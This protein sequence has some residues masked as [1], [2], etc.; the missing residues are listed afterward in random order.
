MSHYSNST[1]PATSTDNYARPHTVRSLLQHQ[2]ADSDYGAAA[3]DMPVY[4][5]SPG[6]CIDEQI[7]LPLSDEQGHPVQNLGPIVTSLSPTALVLGESSTSSEISVKP[8]ENSNSSNYNYTDFLITSPDG[9]KTF[10]IPGLFKMQHSALHV[11][12]DIVFKCFPLF[13]LQH[14]LQYLDGLTLHTDFWVISNPPEPRILQLSTCQ[15]KL[16]S[17]L[18]NHFF[19]LASL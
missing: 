6:Q 10:Q 16:L 17:K 9:F 18:L 8:S 15:P 7:Q 12:L 3:S 1:S 2:Q 5:E 13:H 11:D 4:E 19:L 14:F